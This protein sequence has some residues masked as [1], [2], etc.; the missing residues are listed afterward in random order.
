MSALPSSDLFHP[1][2]ISDIQYVVTPMKIIK[3]YRILPN[4]GFSNV[5]SALSI[6][7][8]LSVEQ[9]EVHVAIECN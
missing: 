6:D 4:Q 8:F 5:A 9:L 2:C 7:P 3:D 1:L